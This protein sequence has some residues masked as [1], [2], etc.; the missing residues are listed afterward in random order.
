[1]SENH[2]SSTSGSSNRAYWATSHNQIFHPSGQTSLEV[3]D[4]TTEANGEGPWK[5]R[6]K[7]SNH[8]SDPKTRQWGIC[9]LFV[10]VIRDRKKDKKCPKP[11]TKLSHHSLDISSGNGGKWSEEPTRQ[12]ENQSFRTRSDPRIYI[13]AMFT[14]AIRDRELYQAI[15]QLSAKAFI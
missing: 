4:Q 9:R 10:R 3:Y 13:F 8:R 7:P 2:P 5:M 1:M 14:R 11:Q 15:D 6:F 12:G